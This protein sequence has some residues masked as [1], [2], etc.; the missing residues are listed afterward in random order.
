MPDEEWDEAALDEMVFALFN[1]AAAEVAAAEEAATSDGVARPKDKATAKLIGAEVPVAAPKG[2]PSK[3]SPALQRF[4][5]TD[6]K[7]PAA[8]PKKRR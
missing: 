8:A 7:K 4:A 6:P 3:V 2:P 1:E 5:F